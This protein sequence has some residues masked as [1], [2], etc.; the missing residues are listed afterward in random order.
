MLTRFTQ[1]G[2]QTPPQP[3]SPTTTTTSSNIF[4][5][6]NHFEGEFRAIKNPQVLLL[7]HAKLDGVNAPYVWRHVCAT[8]AG[9]K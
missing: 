8:L 6:V 3:D 2:A 7:P 9:L 4:Q 1:L 5:G